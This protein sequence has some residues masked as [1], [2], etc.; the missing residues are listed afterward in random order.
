M[1]IMEM[2][3]RAISVRRLGK[4]QRARYRV[5]VEGVTTEPVLLTGSQL[6]HVLGL[7]LGE[8]VA[9]PFKQVADGETGEF[10]GRP[11]LTPGQ[12]DALRVLITAYGS[13]QK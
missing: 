12:D 3:E 11:W 13:A 9:V 6:G 7:I 1:N 8:D 4:T 5:F 10:S 2:I